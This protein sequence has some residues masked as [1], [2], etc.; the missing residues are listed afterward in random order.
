[1][2]EDR[3]RTLLQRH[4]RLAAAATIARDADL[5]ETGLTSFASVQLMLALEEEFEVEFP[6]RM[7]NRRSFASVAAIAAAVEE[8]TQRTEAA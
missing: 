3:I 8:L 1:M 2:T 5:Y 7:L 4:G 6:D